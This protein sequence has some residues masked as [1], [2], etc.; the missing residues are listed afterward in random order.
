[1]VDKDAGPAPWS[2]RELFDANSQSI[3]TITGLAFPRR[4]FGTKWLLVETAGAHKMPVPLIAIRAAGDRLVLPYPR[5][6]IESGPTVLHDRPLSQA[7]QRRLGLHYGFDEFLPGGT[8][9]Q[10]CGLCRVGKIKKTSR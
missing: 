9:C 3:G 6:Y 1:M 4:K 5:S 8:C 10:T 7:E 2:G